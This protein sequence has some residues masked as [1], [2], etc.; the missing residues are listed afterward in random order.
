ML[1]NVPQTKVRPLL[2]RGQSRHPFPQLPSVNKYVNLHKVDTQAFEALST[3]SCTSPGFDG[4]IVGEENGEEK[5]E[6]EKAALPQ[7]FPT[8]V[9]Q[10]TQTQLHMTLPR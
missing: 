8:E 10:K 6:E 3:N 2:A 4:E 9:K 5:E 7:P 1:I